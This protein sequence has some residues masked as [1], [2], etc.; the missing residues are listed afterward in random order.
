LQYN[1]SG[2]A[3][4][5]KSRNHTPVVSRPLTPTAG[6]ADDDRHPSL[7]GY[8]MMIDIGIADLAIILIGLGVGAALALFVVD[9]GRQMNLRTDP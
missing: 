4:S 6:A 8:V 2:I 5:H 7:Q 3:A 1:E 9:T